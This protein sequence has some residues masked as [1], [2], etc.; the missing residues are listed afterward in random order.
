MQTVLTV[1]VRVNK[2]TGNLII[3]WLPGEILDFHNHCLTYIIIL[4]QNSMYTASSLL[5]LTVNATVNTVCFG[6]FGTITVLLTQT[7]F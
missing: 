4:E 7:R 5:L 3:T 6:W 2:E 1:S